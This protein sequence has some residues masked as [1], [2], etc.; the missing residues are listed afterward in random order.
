MRFDWV[1]TGAVAAGALWSAHR[2]LADVST[3]LAGRWR[4]FQKQPIVLRWSV[5]C[6]LAWVAL[7][8]LRFGWRPFLIYGV[9]FGG[10]LLWAA[11]AARTTRA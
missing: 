9:V 5:A 7:R 11:V 10:V 4:S 1:L 3:H 2:L 6:A 8:I